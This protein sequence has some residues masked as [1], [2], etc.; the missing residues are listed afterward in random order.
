MEG[1]SKNDG[2]KKMT[3][4]GE[5]Q[6]REEATVYGTELDL[7]VAVMLL[8]KLPQFFLSGRSARIMGILTT[9]PAVKK[10]H[11]TKHGK[12]IDC[13]VSNYVPF[14]VP[15]LSASS[16]SSTPSPISPSSSSQD[17]ILEVTDTPKIQYKKE[18]EVRVKSF[19]QT[20]CMNPQ[21]PKT[22]IKMVN[23]KKYKEIFRMRCL[24]GYRNSGRILLMKVLQ[25]SFGENQ[26]QGSQDTSKSTHEL[27]MEPRAKVELGLEVSTVLYA[28]SEGPKL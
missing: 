24:I 9:G 2:S 23:R 18:V 7:F 6:T 3:A 11:L 21:K 27:P 28:L 5:V 22:K 4:N 19:G 8:E 13:N 20:R 15:G 12:R 26:E 16:S 10:T 14:L 25:Q 1:Q 17:S